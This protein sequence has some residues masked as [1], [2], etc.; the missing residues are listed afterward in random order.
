MLDMDTEALDTEFSKLRGRRIG[1]AKSY[2]NEDV[3]QGFVWI[4]FSFFFDVDRVK[5][6]GE[7]LVEF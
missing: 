4:G 5:D 2:M 6:F 7:I 3:G 1:W